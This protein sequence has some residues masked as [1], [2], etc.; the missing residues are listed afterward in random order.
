MSSTRIAATR[1]GASSVL[2]HS[3][4][5]R[6]ASC[7]AAGLPAVTAATAIASAAIPLSLFI[8][9]PQDSSSAAP[10]SAPQ[11]LRRGLAVALA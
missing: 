11:A 3:S 10:A 6:A 9:P 5:V 1:A 7:D 2:I 4:V 8:S